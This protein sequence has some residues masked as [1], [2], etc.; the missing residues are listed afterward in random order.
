MLK[1]ERHQLILEA[2]S[3]DAK[4][5][6]AEISKQLKVSEDTVRRDIKE[7]SNQKLLRE[8]RGG[9][10][11]HAPGPVELKERI[12]YATG[13]KQL[14]AQKAVKL[15]KQ[16]QVIILDSGTSALAV[17][18]ALPKDFGITVFTNS[19]PIVNV[20][21]DRKDVEVF[22]AGGRL[23][24][25]SFINVG[26]EA[27]SFFESIRA[28]ICFLGIC[29]IHPELG[30]TGHFYDECAVKKAMIKSAGQVIALST[31]EKLNTAEAFYIC[32]TSALTGMVTSSPDS[33]LFKPYKEQG[34]KIW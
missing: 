24:R 7:L 32:A 20:L 10:I 16:G 6:L 12:N 19:Y 30:V 11:P 14:I 18:D 27:I 15:I 31:P 21:E 1:E 5:V 17:A 4:V 2:L 26:H 8:V 34:I 25:E 9:A 28:D 23:F 3:R 22:F 29:S 33:E 13:K